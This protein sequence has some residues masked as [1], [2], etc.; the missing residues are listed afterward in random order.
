[1]DKMGS[2]EDYLSGLGG[3]GQGVLRHSLL[4]STASPGELWETLLEGV[5]VRRAH[6]H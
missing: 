4:G 3:I 6:R 1:M 5:Q 2:K